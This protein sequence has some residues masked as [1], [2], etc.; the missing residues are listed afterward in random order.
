[1]RV[2]RVRRVADAATRSR[3][4][5]ARRGSASTRAD[6]TPWGATRRVVQDRA[7]ERRDEEG[8]KQA[9]QRPTRCGDRGRGRAAQRAHGGDPAG[10][11]EQRGG[12]REPEPRPP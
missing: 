7:R 10:R 3:A 6:R 5:R 2:A 12:H 1:L 11:E 4:H 9:E 8:R